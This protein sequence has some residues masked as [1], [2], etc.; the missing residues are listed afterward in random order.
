LGGRFFSID[1]LVAKFPYWSPY[2]FAA[3]SPI[4][5]IDANGEAPAKAPPIVEAYLQ[6]GFADIF[7]SFKAANNT[8]TNNLNNWARGRANSSENTIKGTI[9]EALFYQALKDKF[10]WKPTTQEFFGREL[11]GD[12]VTRI[13]QI[14]V[15]QT[16]ETFN[17][18]KTF[19]GIRYWSSGKAILQHD[20]FYGSLGTKTLESKQN[21]VNA[22]VVNYEVKTFDPQRS[23]E[24]LYSGIRDGILKAIAIGGGKDDKIIGVLAIDRDAWLKVANDK[25]FGKALQQHYN[26]LVNSGN[27]LQLVQGLHQTATNE[28]NN[29]KAKINSVPEQ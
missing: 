24:S 29:I 4:Q 26:K 5:F 2:S 10:E 16:I 6:S 27:A 22:W 17:I 3:N 9:G 15:A 12:A 11:Y 25:T 14:D 7:K 8:S 18:K 20:N 21:E 19:L 23:A 13:V 1:P 28:M